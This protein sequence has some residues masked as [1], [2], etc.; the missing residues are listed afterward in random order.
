M[1]D[2]VLKGDRTTDHIGGIEPPTIPEFP[3][4]PGS[5]ELGR[6]APADIVVPVP[7]VSGRH[8]LI[9]ISKHL[10][11]E[12]ACARSRV[13]D[14]NVTITDLEST[15]GTYIDKTELEPMA[16][17]E[18]KVGSEVIFGTRPLLATCVRLVV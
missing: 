8:A 12:K 10:H 11:R 15:N 18:L 13:A 9:Q 16:A 5:F 14:G 4:A 3:L 6:E 7:T 2:L 17:V 1:H